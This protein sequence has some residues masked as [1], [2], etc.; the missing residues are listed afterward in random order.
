MH[1][2]QTAAGKKRLKEIKEARREKRQ[3]K[4]S[5][6]TQRDQL[7][8]EIHA[9]TS[10]RAAKNKTVVEAL[11]TVSELLDQTNRA[12]EKVETRLGD[13]LSQIQ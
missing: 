13:I 5:L 1:W 12:F 9:S 6:N 7:V 4:Q 10:N 3:R 2:T 8:Q 11:E